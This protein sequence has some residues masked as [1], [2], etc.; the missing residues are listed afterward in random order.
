MEEGTQN[1]WIYV[2]ID[3]Y[4]KLVESSYTPM[5]GSRIDPSAPMGPAAGQRRAKFQIDENGTIINGS[6]ASFNGRRV[7][8]HGKAS[9]PLGRTDAVI[10]A[11]TWRSDG[12]GGW[13]CN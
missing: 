9:P 7:I 1:D 8:L 2:K 4:G 11:C 3:D 5:L 10:P 12:A 6:P 13:T